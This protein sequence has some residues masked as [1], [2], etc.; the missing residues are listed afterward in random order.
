MERARGGRRRTAHPAATGQFKMKIAVLRR[1][2]FFTWIYPVFTRFLPGFYPASFVRMSR[3]GA[4]RVK[5]YPVFTRYLPGVSLVGARLRNK[6]CLLESALT[7]HVYS[8]GL[9]VGDVV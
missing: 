7:H 4:P 2:V 6:R 9:P 1:V 3:A 8:V 5:K